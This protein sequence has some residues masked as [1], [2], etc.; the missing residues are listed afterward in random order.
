[1]SRVLAIDPS[2]SRTGVCLQQ[3]ESVFPYSVW[4]GKEF[5]ET[6]GTLFSSISVD[7]GKSFPDAFQDAS[8]Q[9]NQ[10]IELCSVGG[11]THE[12]DKIIIEYPPPIGRWT[13]GL[14]LLDAILIKDLLAFF[15]GEFTEVF[16]IP[17]NAI[18]SY[19]F[20]KKKVSKTEIVEYV[21]EKF[22]LQTLKI[23]HDEASALLLIALVDTKIKGRTPTIFKTDSTFN[24]IDRL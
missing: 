11:K 6:E 1:M 17:P 15:A 19:F 5:P 10:L 12:L 2:Y 9:S 21:K 16:L 24:L 18:N 3:G 22:N 23:N 13:G 20:Q 7:A 8:K 4:K 14:Y